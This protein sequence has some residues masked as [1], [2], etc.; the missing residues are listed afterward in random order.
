MQ[1]SGLG[2]FSTIKSH[3][4]LPFLADENADASESQFFRVP[5]L[6]DPRIKEPC[7]NACQLVTSCVCLETGRLL[8]VNL[9]KGSPH[10]EEVIKLGSL[11]LNL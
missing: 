2:H 10:Q 9:P 8:T 4:W 6:Q 5:K 7:Q 11:N 1:L 3:S